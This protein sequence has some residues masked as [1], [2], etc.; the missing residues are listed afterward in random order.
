[1]AS[2][3]N[4]QRDNFKYT[5]QSSRLD[6]DPE[7]NSPVQ[8]NQN[9]VDTFE[10]NLEKWIEFVQWAR[11]FPDLWYDLIKPEKGGMRLDLDQRVFLRCMSRFVSTYGVFLVDLGKPCL[12]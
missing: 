10:R 12:S 2:R 8:A 1:M 7:F 4:F 6:S 9:K 3:K 11:W 5:K